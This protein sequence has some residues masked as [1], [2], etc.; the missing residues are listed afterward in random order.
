MWRR[1]LEVL[2]IVEVNVPICVFHKEIILALFLQNYADA[3]EEICRDT[4]RWIDYRHSVGLSWQSN[5]W[6][7]Q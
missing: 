5:S 6:D 7:I 3:T 1:L 4:V 2:L